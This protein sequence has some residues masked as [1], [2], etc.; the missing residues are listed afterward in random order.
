MDTTL[1]YIY[2]DQNNTDKRSMSYEYLKW[3]MKQLQDKGVL[4]K[5]DY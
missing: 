5:I 4:I 2:L 1:K 3:A